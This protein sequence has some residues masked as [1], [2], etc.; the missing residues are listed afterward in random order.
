MFVFARQTEAV[1]PIGA[2][3]FELSAIDVVYVERHPVSP[4]L[5]I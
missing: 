2:L 4:A 5:V 1:V 3:N